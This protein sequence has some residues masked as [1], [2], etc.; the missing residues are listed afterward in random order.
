MEM[1]TN[2]I[3]G[4]QNNMLLMEVPRVRLPQAG[5]WFRCGSCQEMKLVCNLHIELASSHIFSNSSQHENLRFKQHKQPPQSKAVCS[6]D[7]FHRRAARQTQHPLGLSLPD[8]K[9]QTT[10]E[11]A[12]A[13]NPRS[14]DLM[15]MSKH[16]AKCAAPAA[17]TSDCWELPNW[18]CA[19]T[20]PRGSTCWGVFTQ[21]LSLFVP[22]RLSNP[23]QL[24]V[25]TYKKK[26]KAATFILW[27]APNKGP[28]EASCIGSLRCWLR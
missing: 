26:S 6:K 7:M 22:V 24:C 8:K 1:R 27:P 4:R 20:W 10:C 3:H 14:T 15:W 13:P 25:W 2:V 28:Y 19:R 9:Y 16:L 23:V 11:Q 18:R 12:L 21:A 5:Y 17:W